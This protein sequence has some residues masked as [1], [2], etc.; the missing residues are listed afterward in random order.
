ML[1]SS[2]L[3][4]Y[5]NHFSYLGIFI[6]FGSIGYLIPIPEEIILTI[7][8][9]LSSIGHSNPWLVFLAALSGVMVGD[10]I[11]YWL[12]YRH[13]KYLLKFKNRVKKEVWDKYERLMVNNIGKTLILSR[14]FISF[15]FLGP[16]IAGSL[17]VRWHLFMA[18]DLPIV[19]AY[20]GAFIYLGIYFRHRY[21]LA[22][23]LVEQLRSF[24][25]AVILIALMI[26]IFRKFF[27]KTNGDSSGH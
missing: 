25:L 27:W 13:G 2:F 20:L 10:N 14:F 21:L 15:R 3:I 5:L 12:C 26:F 19:A 7:L 16:V 4:Q 8:G 17:R 18:Y 9:Y 1:S 6:Y 24:I 22:I 23:S 11:F